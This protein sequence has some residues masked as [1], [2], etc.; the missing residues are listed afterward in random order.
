MPGNV[1]P[2]YVD[3]AF[4]VLGKSIKM[5]VGTLLFRMSA[6]PPRSALEK[7][8]VLK[9]QYSSLAANDSESSHRRL[10]AVTSVNNIYKYRIS[11]EVMVQN[12]TWTATSMMDMYSIVRPALT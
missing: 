10:E 8:G 5:G 6:T 11:S 12:A 1:V 2:N 7:G 9:S 4:S 3:H